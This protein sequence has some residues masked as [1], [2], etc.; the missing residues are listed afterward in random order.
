M[1]GSS[2]GGD[3]NEWT[4]PSEA[5][6]PSD[7]ECQSQNF[8][9]LG[10]VGSW[11]ALSFGEG[12]GVRPGDTVTVYELSA[13]MCDNDMRNDAWEALVS[14]TPEPSGEYLVYGTGKGEFEVAPF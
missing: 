1:G 4:D 14:T 11:I 10:G 3:E 2:I 6:G 13:D 8:V 9:A 7:S 12:F 5:L